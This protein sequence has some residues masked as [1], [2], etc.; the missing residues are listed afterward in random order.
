MVNNDIHFI[1]S[2]RY[3]RAVYGLQET[4]ET[5]DIIDTLMFNVSVHGQNKVVDAIT[6]YK[7]GVVYRG[8]D[9]V[10]TGVNEYRVTDPVVLIAGN[11]SYGV[12]VVMNDGGVYERHFF[13]KIREAT[14]ADDVKFISFTAYGLLENFS[15]T[16]LVAV[17]RT[18]RQVFD[19]QLTKRVD[20][21]KVVKLGAMTSL[22]NNVYTFDDEQFIIHMSGEPRVVYTATVRTADGHVH[23]RDLLVVLSANSFSLNTMIA[24]CD[25]DEVHRLR[26]GVVYRVPNK[27][28]RYHDAACAVLVHADSAGDATRELHVKLTKQAT[29]IDVHAEGFAATFPDFFNRNKTDAMPNVYMFTGKCAVTLTE[30]DRM[31]NDTAHLSMTVRVGDTVRVDLNVTSDNGVDELTFATGEAQNSVIMYADKEVDGTGVADDPLAADASPWVPRVDGTRVYLR[32]ADNL[33]DEQEVAVSIAGA[34]VLND[35]DWVVFDAERVKAITVDEG[36]FTIKS[37][38]GL[39][40]EENR[41]PVKIS[42]HTV[43]EL[44]SGPSPVLCKQNG[45]VVIQFVDLD[46]S[47]RTLRHITVVNND[48]EV[49]DW[50]HVLNAAYTTLER[51]LDYSVETV[52]KLTDDVLEYSV[53]VDGQ[54]VS[55]DYGATDM[56]L[57][58]FTQA[59]TM[60]ELSVIGVYPVTLTTTI[61][62]TGNVL[63]VKAKLE[64][65][66]RAVVRLSSVNMFVETK[67]MIFSVKSDTINFVD[68]RSVANQLPINIMEGSNGVYFI[69]FERGRASTNAAGYGSYANCFVYEGATKL[70]TVPLEAIY[71]QGCM[72]TVYAYVDTSRLRVIH[73][74]GEAWLFNVRAGRTLLTRINLRKDAVVAEYE[75]AS[76]AIINGSSPLMIA[77]ERLASLSAMLGGARVTTVDR[78]MHLITVSDLEEPMYIYGLTADPLA[79]DAVDNRVCSDNDT[80]RSWLA[81]ETVTWTLS[82]K[83]RATMLGRPVARPLVDD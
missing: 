4:Y 71:G 9:L 80:A 42:K 61:P 60:Q 2:D 17:V 64:A 81:D 69:K 77:D 32:P 35:A 74:E 12:R 33:D 66:I 25:D 56:G 55:V 10:K 50:T 43:D 22:G 52:K 57:T 45:D 14:P 26:G 5:A 1:L 51:A 73:R 18:P 34:G 82:V 41:A 37:F 46:M 39:N 40:V 63:T 36:G 8:A 48:A 28:S 11:H 13:L 38:D 58:N 54:A 65:T 27:L 6:L 76:T 67:S 7:N 21:G 23:S 62:S 75:F 72:E 20:N 24:S 29:T 44:K 47:A 70:C 49:D 3:H 59:F 79:M 83:N 78:V 31:E 30:G 53:H 16:R 15:T 19:V 68:N